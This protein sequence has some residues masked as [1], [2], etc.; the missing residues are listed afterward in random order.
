MVDNPLEGAVAL[1]VNIA[2]SSRGAI[3]TS[4]TIRQDLVDRLGAP[5]SR[6]QGRNKACCPDGTKYG[7][8]GLHCDEPIQPGQAIENGRLNR[9][10]Y[11]C[12][13][14]RKLHYM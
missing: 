4:E 9:C 14:K 3:G 7:S 2:G 1:D 6:R 12:Q 11:S 13:I 10:Q 5:L 8:W